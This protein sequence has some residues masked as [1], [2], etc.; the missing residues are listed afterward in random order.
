MNHSYPGKFITVEGMDASGK[1]SNIPVLAAAF[2]SLGY[3]VITTREPGGTKLAEDIRNLILHTEMDGVTELLLFLAA[4]RNHVQTKIIPALKEGKIVISDR[5]HDSTY[6]YQGYGRKLLNDI[7]DLSKFVNGGI[8]PDYTVFFDLPFEVS[9]E[10]LNLRT[11]KQ[12]RLDKE[13]EEFR[14]QMY[15]GYRARLNPLSEKL[16]PFEAKL[17]NIQLI[18]ANKTISEV[19]EQVTNWVVTTFPMYSPT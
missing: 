9:L 10:R 17:R 3:E 19:S 7:L 11:D 6:A 5:F 12:D 13:E 14:K 1:S 4:R 8:D 16:D 18:D 15:L 2:T